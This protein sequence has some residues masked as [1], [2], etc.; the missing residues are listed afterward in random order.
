M[1]LWPSDPR[2][3]NTCLRTI[4]WHCFGLPSAS[5]YQR[6]RL[7]VQA[8]EDYVGQVEIAPG[9]KVIQA[10]MTRL[11]PAHDPPAMY[12]VRNG[13]AA[14]VACGNSPAGRSRPSR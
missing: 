4:L 13:R 5:L 12:V 3:G 7:V 8:L 1:Y 14:G 9:N 11:Y 10:V 2:N 6:D